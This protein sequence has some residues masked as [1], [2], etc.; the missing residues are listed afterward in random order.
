MIGPPGTVLVRDLP[1]PGM[2]L[3]PFL[4]LRFF[5]LVRIESPDPRFQN[6]VP[7]QHCH[8]EIPTSIGF[9]Q[10]A[11]RL[12]PG[13]IRLAAGPAD[14]LTRIPD[15]PETGFRKRTERRFA[16]RVKL[17]GLP[18][19]QG[20]LHFFPGR[21]KPAAHITPVIMMAISFIARSSGASGSL[22]SRSG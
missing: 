17:A 14:F 6:A 4:Q 10:P 11:L 19:R 7:V 20:G 21:A 22:A 2:L 9:D 15:P 12:Y 8:G 13:Q 18:V 16:H 5:F 3:Y 1:F